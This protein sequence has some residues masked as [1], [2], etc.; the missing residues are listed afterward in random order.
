MVG[1]QAVEIVATVPTAL[2]AEFASRFGVR[3]TLGVLTQLLASARSEVVIG[4]PFIQGEAG[5]HAGPLG[6]A[7]IAALRRGVHV[8]VIST[9]ASLASLDISML[10]E[11]APAGFRAFQ[12]RV[13]VERPR[14]L[15]SHAKLCVSDGEHAYLGSANITQAG[16]SGHLEMGVLLH[17]TPAR[18]VL[19]FVRGLVAVEYLIEASI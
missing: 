8:D 2:G 14:S 18:Q 1:Q 15:G 12:P 13:N 19:A 7:L 6:I 11:A 3:T 16:I 9:G 5:L 17:G 4:A 10:R